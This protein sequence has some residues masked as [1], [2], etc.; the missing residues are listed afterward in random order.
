MRFYDFIGILEQF[1]LEYIIFDF[2]TQFCGRTYNPD[3]ADYFY[4]PLVRD[5][6]YRVTLQSSIRNRAPSSAEIAL[7][8][9]LEKKDSTAW[10]RVFNV[11][12]HY[13]W[14]KGGADHIIVMPG[15]FIVRMSE[16]VLI[17]LS[18]SSS[19]QFKARE[20]YA[21]FFPLHESSSHSNIPS[22]RIL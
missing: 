11:T 6:E 7:L 5:A 15:Q 1:A 13:F 22:S 9:I 16:Y 3:E 17:C 21:W 12:D 18:S 10:K 2:F 4:L 19:Y 20:Q 14:E 8:D